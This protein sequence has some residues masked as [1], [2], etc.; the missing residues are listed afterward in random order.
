MYPIDSIYINGIYRP[1]ISLDSTKR[2]TFYNVQFDS[3]IKVVFRT[4]VKIQAEA[5][6]GTI[7]LQ[8]TIL[9]IGQSICVSYKNNNDTFYKFDSV[10]LDHNYN[11]NFL[12]SQNSFC[13]YKPNKS[14]SLRVVYSPYPIIKIQPTK[15]KN[16]ICQNSNLDSPVI[17]RARASMN[18]LDTHIK[19]KKIQ[20]YY[21]YTDDNTSYPLN[22][23][24]CTGILS[25]F[26]TTLSLP[27]NLNQPSDSKIY[28]A[29]ITNDRNLTVTSQT[30][31][32]VYI[33]PVPQ[34][35][36]VLQNNSQINCAL[37]RDSIK[38]KLQ[39]LNFDTI[40][41]TK[42]QL[43]ITDSP[44]R[45]RSSLINITSIIDSPN[46][47]YSE[48]L[49]SPIQRI[50][51]VYATLTNQFNCNYISPNLQLQWYRLIN[52]NRFDTQSAI[53][54][55]LD[56]TK[57][58]TFSINPLV[59]LVDIRFTWYINQFPFYKGADS[60]P[61][62]NDTLFYPFNDKTKDSLY[63]FVVS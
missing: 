2:Y 43:Y 56:K 5:I 1:D 11:Q 14:H 10:I 33:K 54:C 22:C 60:I 44:S 9:E 25:S 37:E 15:H 58:I 6:N 42:V 55:Y 27:I 35:T 34:S 52:I 21:K 61:N 39:I 63:Y 26:D 51:Y 18:A 20:W 7:S 16:I 38:V 41:Y 48:S 17:V 40:D 13:F 30:S 31:G 32:I 12:D 29:V 24:G 23:L 62:S 46:M 45:Y 36:V 50:R 8:D 47:Y 59:K 49:Y 19:L 4:R 3:S 28:Y 53:Y 57:P